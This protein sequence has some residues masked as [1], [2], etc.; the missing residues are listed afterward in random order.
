MAGNG[1]LPRNEW[2]AALDRI[3]E[4]HTGEHITIELLDPEVGH[5]YEAE[6]LPFAYLDYDPKDDTA[7]VAVGGK[8]ARY[9]VVLRHMIAH[10][11]EVDVAT[12][13]I[14]EPAVR[15]VGSDGTATLITFF[16]AGS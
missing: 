14:P 13:D 16:K 10:P 4:E 12:H 11:T 3:T 8:S 1:T 6:R 7:I 2:K 5:Q 15:I 9:P